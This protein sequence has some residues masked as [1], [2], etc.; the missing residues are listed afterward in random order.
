MP[1]FIVL[2]SAGQGDQPLYSRLWGSGFLDSKYQG[3]QF[4]PGKDPVL[5]LSNPDGICQSGRRAMHD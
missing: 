4:R 3:V 2:V 1:S 5:Y